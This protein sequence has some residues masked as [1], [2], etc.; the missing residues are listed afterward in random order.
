MLPNQIMHLQEKVQRIQL[1]K[2]TS[3]TVREVCTSTLALIESYKNLEITCIDVQHVVKARMETLD[4]EFQKAADAERRIA[5]LEAE[6]QKLTVQVAVLT[7]VNITYKEFVG[8]KEALPQKAPSYTS[9]LLKK[10]TEVGVVIPVGTQAENAIKAVVDE[11]WEEEDAERLKDWACDLPEDFAG[12]PKD[13]DGQLLVLCRKAV[14][15]DLTY[16]E[17]CL[18]REQARQ[19]LEHLNPD[20]R[21]AAH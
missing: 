8:I 20:D 18:M 21:D 9:A 3:D 7:A 14:S 16:N 5:E 1:L 19:R 11:W 4:K 6:N 10:P 15:R 12:I 17:K 2:S 13:P